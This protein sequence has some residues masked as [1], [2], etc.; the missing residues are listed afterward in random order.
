[1]SESREFK[2]ATAKYAATVL[3]R[4]LISTKTPAI[5]QCVV[6]YCEEPSEDKLVEL[7]D[8]LFEELE[9][10]STIS[11]PVVESVESNGVMDRPDSPMPSILNNVKNWRDYED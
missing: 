7:Y 2:L 10:E 4:Y 5:T 3:A 9:N 6:T 8:L 1:M 11:G